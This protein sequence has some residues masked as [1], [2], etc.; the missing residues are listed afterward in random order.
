MG[1]GLKF[2]WDQDFWCN[3]PHSMTKQFVKKAYEEHLTYNVN[4]MMIIPANT[5]SSKFW[6]IYIEDVA[7][8]HAIKGRIRFLV[9]GKPSK[10][11]SRNAYVCVIWRKK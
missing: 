3:P 1:D 11:A 6:H 5:M 8:V 9:D 7:E 4:G 10:F 2:R